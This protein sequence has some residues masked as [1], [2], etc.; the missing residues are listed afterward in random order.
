VEHARKLH[1]DTRLEFLVGDACNLPFANASFDHSLSMLVLQFVPKADVAI[2]EMRRVTQS[3]GTVAAATWDAR[4]GLTFLRM[5]FDTAAVLDPEANRI[6]ARL[7]SQ[8]LTR[9]GDLTRAW[10]DAGLLNVIED[11]VTIRMDFASFAD[12]WAPCEGREGPIAG[13]IGA[14]APDAKARLRELVQ[15]AYLDG[16]SDGPRSYT[17]TALVVK[18]TVP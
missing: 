6:R 9:P 12:F 14:L 18:G 13:Y 17:A 15:C 5:I 10:V 16:E 3:G 8:H 11:M 1:G 4:G 7:L 2:G